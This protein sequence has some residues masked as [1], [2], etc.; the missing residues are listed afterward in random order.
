MYRQTLLLPSY[1]PPLCTTDFGKKLGKKLPDAGIFHLARHNFK[2]DAY[3]SD[4]AVT[5]VMVVV[6]ILS[7][8]RL[9]LQQ[10][11]RR[12]GRVWAGR[13]TSSRSSHGA[14]NTTVPE[15]ALDDDGT[16]ATI[17]VLFISKCSDQMKKSYSDSFL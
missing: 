1:L 17:F 7:L 14:Y 10:R 12:A 9:Q 5:L 4:L 3:E 13:I 11:D 15:L 2:M 8:K 6:I 16:D